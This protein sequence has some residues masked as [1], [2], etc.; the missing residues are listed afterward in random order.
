MNP[1]KIPTIPIRSFLA[2]HDPPFDSNDMRR[3]K[4]NE[5][6]Y[7]GLGPESPGERMK[8]VLPGNRDAVYNETCSTI[9]LPFGP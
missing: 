8:M 6:G 2:H 4:I 1:Q 3:Q 5:P 7:P 9:D